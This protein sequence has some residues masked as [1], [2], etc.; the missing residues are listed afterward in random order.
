[1]LICQEDLGSVG[2]CGA[3]KWP[4]GVQSLVGI[5]LSIFRVRTWPPSPGLWKLFSSQTTSPDSGMSPREGAH[6]HLLQGP[7]GFGDVLRVGPC[8]GC[9]PSAWAF[10]LSPPSLLP[11]LFWSPKSI[12]MF[13]FRSLWF[14][15]S[16]VSMS[17]LY[18][19]V[20]GRRN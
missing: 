15:L 9:Q 6:P 17:G 5:L 14:F 10:S 7:R 1:M 19:G 2:A 20:L 8:G 12:V 18:G 4:A 13:V 11:A 16:L 3:P